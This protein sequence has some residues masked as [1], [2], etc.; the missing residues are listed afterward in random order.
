[1]S[2]QGT[3]ALHGAGFFFDQNQAMTMRDYR[4]LRAYLDVFNIANRA[5]FNNPTVTVGTVTGADR[6]DAATFL[7]LRSIRDGGPT[8]TA[9]F[10]IRYS[11]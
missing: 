8:R 7:V 4:Q 6:R 11:F 5:N 1:M 2:K 3:N 10:N 9:Q